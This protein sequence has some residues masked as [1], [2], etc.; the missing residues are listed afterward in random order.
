MR[1]ALFAAVLALP[2]MAQAETL[3]ILHTND[4]HSRIEPIS[5]YNSGCRP[6]DNDEGKCFG[7]AARMA[8]AVR[9]ARADAHNSI[10]VD[11][12]D[13]FQGSLYYTFYKGKAAAEMMNA[14][15]YDAMTVGNHEFDDGPEV[16][17]GFMDALDFP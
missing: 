5:K 1:L 9:A 3:T 14:I 6:G 15:G 8:T 4:V 11:G 16:L 17:R 7:G 10:L 13:Q 2:A 12:G